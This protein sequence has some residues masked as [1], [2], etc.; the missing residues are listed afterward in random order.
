MTAGTT[1]G[2]TCGSGAACG[3]DDAGPKIQLCQ[4]NTQCPKGQICSPVKVLSDQ[5]SINNAVLGA[6]MAP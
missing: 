4:F 5:T 3:S 1:T 2:A 6:C